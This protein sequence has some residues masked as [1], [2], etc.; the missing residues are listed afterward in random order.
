MHNEIQYI[1]KSKCRGKPISRVTDLEK[2]FYTMK[3]YYKRL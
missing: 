3:Y 1:R 2:A